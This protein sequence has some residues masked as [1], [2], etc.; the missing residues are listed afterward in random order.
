MTPKDEQQDRILASG[1][2]AIREQDK[3]HLVLAYL[4]CLCLIP[5]LTVKDS[6]F[7]T[8]HAKQGLVLLGAELAV[9]VLGM[10]L[11]FLGGGC[12]AAVVNLAL[13]VVSVLAII[14]ALKGERWR[15]PLLS[16]LAEKL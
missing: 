1:G 10:L 15:L 7:V 2:D 16:D 6:P 13:L 12:V 5:L 8:W 14:R 3:I 9:G 11:S 4:G